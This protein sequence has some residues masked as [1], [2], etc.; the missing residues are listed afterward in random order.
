MG[1]EGRIG[2][3]RYH[4][5]ACIT[6][7]TG[8]I[9]AICDREAGWEVGLLA[10]GE[11]V[12]VGLEEEADDWDR[13]QVTTREVEVRQRAKATRPKYLGRDIMEY[14]STNSLLY[15]H[16]RHFHQRSCEVELTL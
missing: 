5:H 8:F 7:T 3:D 4:D 11:E 6:P 10:D 12:A 1:R 14:L 2:R 13:F 16:C 9:F 15:H